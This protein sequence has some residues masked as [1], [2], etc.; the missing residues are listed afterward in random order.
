MTWNN[1][2]WRAESI[3]DDKLNSRLRSN[4]LALK[5]PET[6]LGYSLSA[7]LSTTSTSFVDIDN[8]FLLT[9]GTNGGDVMVSFFASPIG[10]FAFDFT[11]DGR[12]QGGVDGIC[13]G[14]NALTELNASFVWLVQDLPAGEHT[15]VLQW[16]THGALLTI[17]SN[18]G[19]Y[20]F[21]REVS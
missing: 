9:L 3:T 19:Y 17:N 15:F 21:V 10:A 18:A 2:L 7:L 16:K 11:V 14:D 8:A 13:K 5:S 12:R 6:D 20:F 4:M 1:P